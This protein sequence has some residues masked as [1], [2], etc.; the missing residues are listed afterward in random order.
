MAY[1]FKRENGRWYVRYKNERGV[2]TMASCGK[3]ATAA[4]AEI[5]RKNYDAL[6]LNRRNK[7]VVREVDQNLYQLMSY[8]KEHVL[9]ESTTGRDKG[10]RTKRR[11]QVVIE[12]FLKWFDPDNEKMLTDVTGIEIKKYFDYLKAENKAARTRHEERRVLLKFFKWAMSQHYC[13]SNPVEKIENPRPETK[14]PFFYTSEQLEKIWQH[15]N[16]IYINVFKFLYYTGLRIG[17][18]Q[19]LI[20]SD[21]LKDQN[22]LKIRVMEGNKTKREE[23]IPLS[24]KAVKILEEQF[25]EKTDDVIFHNDL[26][27]PL[28][29]DNIYRNFKR[30]LKRAGIKEGTPHTLRHT[31]ASHLVIK[32]VSLYIVRDLLRHKSIEETQIYAHLSKESLQ[33]PVEL[34]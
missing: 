13:T 31:F 1:K 11:E 25:I 8:F 7:I 12:N 4:E 28:D 2:W 32:G 24:S 30:T 23:T 17:E 29:N 18:L 3:T 15:S 21:W 16:S 33:A 19:H 20:W 34:L 22:L 9:I 6:E 10:H 14:L 27:G 26:G 5:I